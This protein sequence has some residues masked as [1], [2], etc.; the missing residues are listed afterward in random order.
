LISGRRINQVKVDEYE[1]M[2]YASITNNKNITIPLY[3]VD[4]NFEF[5]H[6]TITN[7]IISKTV[8]SI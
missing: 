6:S 2:S 8:N 7:R 5:V 4:Y 3:D 1:M